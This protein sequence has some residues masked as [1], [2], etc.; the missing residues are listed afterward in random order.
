[1]I[2]IQISHI[3]LKNARNEL[4][5][6]FNT[7]VKSIPS[8][9]TQF[10]NIYNSE[11][12]FKNFTNNNSKKNRYKE[13]INILENKDIKMK[14]KNNNDLSNLKGNNIIN[15]IFEIKVCKNIDNKIFN[16]KDKNQQINIYDISKDIKIEDENNIIYNGYK[17]KK[18]KIDNYHN[19]K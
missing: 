10:K 4:K 14:E 8:V 18:T 17:F 12:N 16:E 5:Y 7:E 15:N 11:N 3:L 19:K 13:K 2:I 6:N 1:M 9:I